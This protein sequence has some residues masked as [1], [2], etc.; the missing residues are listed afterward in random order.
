MIGRARQLN[1]ALLNQFSPQRVVFHHVPKCGG[2]SVG[3]ALRMRYLS[4]QATVKPEAS[5]QAF[6]AFSGRTDT[7]QMMLDVNDLRKQMLLYLMYD[8]VRCISTHVPFSHVAHTEFKGSYKFITL[9]RDPV[10]RFLSHYNWNRSRPGSHG[11]V[12]E[13]FDTFLASRRAG[14]MGTEFV[15][16]FADMP[17]DTDLKSSEAIDR[18][19][20]HLKQFDIVGRLDDL[21]GFVRDIRQTLGLRVRIG[22]R[23]K[24]SKFD[25]VVSR[26]SLNQ[27]Q[28]AQ[29]QAICAPD[30]EVWK[31]VFPT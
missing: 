31:R 4:S 1:Q 15:E 21:D 7:D 11:H 23:N 22:H 25:N 5:F 9:L 2:T 10:S 18:A 3:R 29:V 20:H 19:V 26:A 30:I 17:T 8:D 28:L 12:S 24:T 14:M 6:K 13:D 27:A 16:I